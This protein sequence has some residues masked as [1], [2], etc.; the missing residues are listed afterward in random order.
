ML[1]DF[2]VVKIFATYEISQVA[3]FCNMVLF[4]VSFCNSLYLA[5]LRL[6]FLKLNFL[7]F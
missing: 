3:K 7:I 5:T 4:I 2:Q 1:E 6:T